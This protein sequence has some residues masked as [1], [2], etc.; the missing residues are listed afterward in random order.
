MWNGNTGSQ[1]GKT[2]RC[3]WPVPL[4]LCRLY[5]LQVGEYFTRHEQYRLFILRKNSSSCNIGYLISSK[6]PSRRIFCTMRT[7]WNGW[8]IY[9]IGCSHLGK[10]LLVARWSPIIGKICNIWQLTTQGGPSLCSITLCLCNTL[11]NSVVFRSDYPVNFYLFGCT[12]YLLVGIGQDIAFGSTICAPFVDQYSFTLF[13]F[14]WLVTFDITCILDRFQSAFCRTVYG[15]STVG[16]YFT[17][18][19]AICVSRMFSL[20]FKQCL[21]P[22]F[23]RA[24][25]VTF[26]ASYIITALFA[27]TFLCLSAVPLINFNTALLRA[28]NTESVFEYKIA[29]GL[30]FSAKFVT[31]MVGVSFSDA[32]CFVATGFWV[33]FSGLDFWKHESVFTVFTCEFFF[34]HCTLLFLKFCI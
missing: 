17:T 32:L 3:R 27:R 28:G 23:S 14:F 22:A 33:V 12:F 25:F 21:V 9:N 19:L 13:A 6:P 11:F 10:I 18:L 8:N 30:A 7:V 4:C 31:C 20:S 34:F 16:N 29:A 24:V 2:R 26:W 5:V 1:G 15:L